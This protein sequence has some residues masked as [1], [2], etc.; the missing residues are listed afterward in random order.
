MYWS[1]L[2]IIQLCVAIGGQPQISRRNAVTEE[3]GNKWPKA[4]GKVI[5]PFGI[6]VGMNTEARNAITA[7]IKDFHKETCIEFIPRTNEGEGDYI[8]IIHTGSKCSSFVGRVG[9]GQ[10]LKLDERCEFK[11]SILH[12]LMHAIGFYNEHQRPDR[13]EYIT[14]NW[15]NIKPEY[16]DS[17]EKI[18]TSNTLGAPYDYCSI[19]NY[20]NTFY[21]T[22]EAGDNGLHTFEVKNKTAVCPD[23]RPFTGVAQRNGFTETDIAKI[24]NLYEC[25]D[26]YIKKYQIRPSI[27]TGDDLVDKDELNT[28]L[29]ESWAYGGACTGK[30]DLPEKTLK[31]VKDNCQ[32][33]CSTCRH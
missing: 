24:N 20:G 21:R 5:V 3:S 23:G 18:P 19:M 8:N 22:D 1:L 2:A 25:G 15:D 11:G 29:C 7:A 6:E 13:D 9:G 28:G 14:I 32:K 33:S 31:Y 30:A 12:E 4:D 27:C 10:P 26:G 17:Y 16:Q